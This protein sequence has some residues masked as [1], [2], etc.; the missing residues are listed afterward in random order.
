[1]SEPQRP[2][3]ATAQE[4]MYASAFLLG[5]R[6]QYLSL[7]ELECPLVPAHLQ[8]LCDPLLIGCQPHDLL[9][10]VPHKL[11]ALAEP[12]QMGNIYDMISSHTYACF[13]RSSS[14]LSRCSLNGG[15]ASRVQ[16]QILC[17]AHQGSVNVKFTQLTLSSDVLSHIRNALR[18]LARHYWCS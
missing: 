10:Y 4:H 8:Q 17:P 6:W 15:G 9:H 18:L 16:A 12:L 1:M 11:D 3:L 14:R 7:A 2:F 5:M 13:Q